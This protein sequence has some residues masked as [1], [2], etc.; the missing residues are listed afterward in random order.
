MKRKNIL[1]A[2]LFAM[3]ST[4]VWCQV[5]VNLAPNIELTFPQQPEVFDTLGQ[6]VFNYSDEVGYY[7]CIIRRNAVPAGKAPMDL[8]SFYANLYK[9]LQRPEEECQLIK[10]TDL[11]LAGIIGAEFQTRCKEDPSFQKS[12]T[13]G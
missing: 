11:V 2:I 12:D 10:Q 4:S 5:K 7:A 8:K 1:I 6:K 13:K 9:S 3:Y